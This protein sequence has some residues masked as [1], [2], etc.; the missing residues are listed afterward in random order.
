MEIRHTRKWNRHWLCGHVIIL[1][2]RGHLVHIFVKMEAMEVVSVCLTV[3]II[4]I[5]LAILLS[6]MLLL[7]RINLIVRFTM[8]LI[9][10]WNYDLEQWEVCKHGTHKNFKVGV[11]DSSSLKNRSPNSKAG[12]PLSKI[13][14]SCSFI[15]KLHIF[16]GI[17]AINTVQCISTDCVVFIDFHYFFNH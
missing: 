11:R 15:W 4:I 2:N 9:R 1:S 17:Y 13:L 7:N 16:V 3:L 6:L 12:V 14:E 5:L 10:I 8:T